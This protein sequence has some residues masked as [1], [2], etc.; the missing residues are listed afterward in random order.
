MPVYSVLAEQAANVF[1]QLFE[2]EWNGQ[3]AGFYR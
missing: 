1:S 3:K 2:K